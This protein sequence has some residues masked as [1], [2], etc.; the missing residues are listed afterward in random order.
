MEHMDSARPPALALVDERREQ[1]IKALFE[2]EYSNL[3]RLAS[4]LVDDRGSA[5]D[6]VQDS[7]V[8][9]YRAWD[10]V[11]DPASAQA[12]LRSIVMN[13]ARS[14]LRHRRMVRDRRT[15]NR[16]EPP[17][18]AENAVASEE[19]RGVI[20]AIQQ[21]SRRCRE[22]LVLRYYGDLSER[23]IAETLGIAPG[24][25]KSYAH[26]GMQRIAEILEASR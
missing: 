15:P 4:L 22:V 11:V 5:E 26:E 7:F 21:L 16:P 24:T 25:V 12:Y 3:V 13:T 20:A 23:E 14:A 2:S 8:K 9:L 6:V 17:G 10:R 19:Q 1:G 18:P